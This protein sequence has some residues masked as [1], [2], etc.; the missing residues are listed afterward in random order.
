MARLGLLLE[1]SLGKH[2]EVDAPVAPEVAAVVLVVFVGVAVVVEILAQL[3]VHLHEEV[4]LA[5]CNPVELGLRGEEA[6][7]LGVELVGVLVH[8]GCS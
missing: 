4:F 2:G 6:A 5:D 3:L 7:E 8:A 1:Q